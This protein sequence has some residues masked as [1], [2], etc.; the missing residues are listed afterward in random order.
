M[1]EPVCPQVPNKSR[2]PPPFHPLL[3]VRP[4]SLP[5][6]IK[7]NI[8][9]DGR[10]LYRYITHSFK[11]FKQAVSAQAFEQ[12]ATA[13]GRSQ[14]AESPEEGSRCRSLGDP[15]LSKASETFA[16]AMQDYIVACE[17]LEEAA[18]RQEHASV[19]FYCKAKLREYPWRSWYQSSFFPAPMLGTL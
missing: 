16:T 13:S 12:S 4:L 8:A 3:Y 2:G 14:D 7:L 1:A 10:E 17:R 9:A 15:L 19:V 6:S 11:V 18:D 5:L